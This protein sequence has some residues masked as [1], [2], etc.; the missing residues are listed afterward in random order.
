MGNHV[1]DG[2]NMGVLGAYVGRTHHT[3]PPDS[4]DTRQGAGGAD[5]PDRKCSTRTCW[6][7]R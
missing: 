7:C 2:C 5:S 1:G 4:L 6:T 3:H